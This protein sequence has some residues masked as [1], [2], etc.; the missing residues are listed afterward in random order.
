M[1]NSQSAMKEDD[2][3]SQALA[4]FKKD[5]SAFL[6]NNLIYSSEYHHVLRLRDVIK[7]FSHAFPV[8]QQFVS[9]LY[10]NNSKYGFQLNTMVDII[11]K[12]FD[13]CCVMVYAKHSFPPDRILDFSNVFDYSKMYEK[14][15]A[16]AVLSG[17]SWKDPPSL[18]DL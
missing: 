14:Y 5:F 4:V 18:I 10:D 8:H 2:D 6:S 7:R 11:Q 16:G 3:Y 13:S 15:Y 17:F 1:G 12:E 9:D